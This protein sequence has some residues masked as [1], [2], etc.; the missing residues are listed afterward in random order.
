MC[1]SLKEYVYPQDG[2]TI[3]FAIGMVLTAKKEAR[4]PQ[5]RDNASPLCG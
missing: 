2:V 3:Q 4:V 1:R 5:N